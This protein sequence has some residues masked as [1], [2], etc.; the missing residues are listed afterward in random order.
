LQIPLSVEEA[1]LSRDFASKS[2]HLQFDG[3]SPDPSR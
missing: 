1:P 2:F 3:V